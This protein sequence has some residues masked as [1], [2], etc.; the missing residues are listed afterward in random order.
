LTLQLTA[1][2]THGKSAK[3]RLQEGERILDDW[4]AGATVSEL[5]DR[6][7]VSVATLYRRRDTALKARLA[8]TVDQYRE[9]ENVTLDNTMARW[10][11]QR[12]AAAEMVAAGTRA[13]D[14]Q[15][16]EKGMN[17][18]AKA[19][20]GIVRTSERRARLNGLDAPVKAEVTVT[21]TTP[22]DAAVEAL[23]AEVE[24]TS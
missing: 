24:A 4:S 21:H 7:Q 15:L 9:R 2:Q 16:V 6:Y 22:V 14:W 5:C 17:L 10:T 1:Q 20:D 3:D 12:D 23:V 8:S 11:R 19:L 13:E 18:H